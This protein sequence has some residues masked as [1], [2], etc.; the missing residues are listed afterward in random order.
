MTSPTSA[1]PQVT[2]KAKTNPG[3]E[4]KKT[5]VGVPAQIQASLKESSQKT[6]SKLNPQGRSVVSQVTQPTSQP[7]EKVQTQPQSEQRPGGESVVA[8]TADTST[9]PKT[10]TQGQADA[11]KKWRDIDSALAQV[12]Q[13]HVE[14]GDKAQHKNVLQQWGDNLRESVSGDRDDQFKNLRQ[15]EEQLVALQQ[16]ARQGADVGAELSRTQES[17]NAKTQRVSEA[18]EFN[19]QVG[20]VAY[21]VGKGV[22]VTAAA[23]A[24]VGTG[25]LAGVAMAGVA[26]LVTTSSAIDGATVVGAKLTGDE[27]TGRF[28]PQLTV[29]NSIGGVAAQQVSGEEVSAEQWQTGAWGSVTGASTGKSILDAR[30]VQEVMKKSTAIERGLAVSRVNAVNTLQQ[31][32]VQETADAARIM[33]GKGTAEEK[34]QALVEHVVDTVQHLPGDIAFNALSN[35]VGSQIRTSTKVMDVAANLV[36]DAGTN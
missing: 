21:T 33:S 17:F 12:R 20:A 26:A 23:A 10:P 34:Q 14:Y 36:L 24:V 4:K 5:P 16:R 22:A 30:N 27:G 25:G 13:S 19:A 3:S 6:T 1:T 31:T 8:A 35:G 2:P 11:E 15:T 7:N 9:A 28:G 29:D 18:Q 32:A